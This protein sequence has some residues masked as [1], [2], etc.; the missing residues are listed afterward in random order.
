MRRFVLRSFEIM[1]DTENERNMKKA[2]ETGHRMAMT[3]QREL[4]DNLQEWGE[5]FRKKQHGATLTILRARKTILDQSARIYELE[6]VLNRLFHYT[7]CTTGQMV[8][9]EEILPQNNHRRGS[10]PRSSHQPT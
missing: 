5:E 9:I 2:I 1:H 6:E 7:D 4:I 10:I 8:I 3:P